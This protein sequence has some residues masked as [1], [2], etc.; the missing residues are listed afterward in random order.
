MS[1]DADPVPRGQTNRLTLATKISAGAAKVYSRRLNSKGS[2]WNGCLKSIF[3]ADLIV[4]RYGHHCA[5]GRGV[6]RKK[7]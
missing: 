4:Q 3:F 7:S 1:D 2:L 5:C 6:K